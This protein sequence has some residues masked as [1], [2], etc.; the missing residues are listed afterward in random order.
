LS[1]LRG[2]IN[3]NNVWRVRAVILGHGLTCYKS[4]INSGWKVIIPCK[5]TEDACII[6]EKVE[7]RIP[8]EARKGFCGGIASC[9]VSEMSKIFQGCINVTQFRAQVNIFCLQNITLRLYAA[10]L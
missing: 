8:E 9:D 3:A 1:L 4:D 2:I 7:R 10:W 5:D 6:F